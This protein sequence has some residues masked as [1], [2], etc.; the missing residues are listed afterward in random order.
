MSKGLRNVTP[1]RLV[2]LGREVR[3]LSE[4]YRAQA[5]VERYRGLSG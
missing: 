5:F 1:K 2:G 4:S 3:D